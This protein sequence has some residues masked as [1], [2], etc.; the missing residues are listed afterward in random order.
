MSSHIVKDRLRVIKGGSNETLRGSKKEKHKF[1]IAEGVSLET[2][3]LPEGKR[4]EGPEG[5]LHEQ[6]GENTHLGERPAEGM[7]PGGEYRR[8]GEKKLWPTKP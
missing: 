7:R 1:S 2:C 8:E 6:L 4:T 5:K 3:G